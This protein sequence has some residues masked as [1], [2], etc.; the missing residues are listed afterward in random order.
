M[1]LI[2]N[3]FQVEQL[4]NQTAPDENIEH[5]NALPL[6]VLKNEIVPIQE[7][8]PE[9]VPNDESK[10]SLFLHMPILHASTLT[11]FILYYSNHT[12]T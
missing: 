6:E 4:K 5:G 12:C 8:R 3:T 11:T 2:Y 1:F 7:P 10:V 9:Q